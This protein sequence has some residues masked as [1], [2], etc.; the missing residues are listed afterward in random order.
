MDTELRNRKAAGDDQQDPLAST[1]ISSANKHH[2]QPSSSSTLSPD[3]AFTNGFGADPEKNGTG[4]S[5]VPSDGLTRFPLGRK[6]TETQKESLVKESAETAYGKTPNG[7]SKFFSSTLW[8]ACFIFSLL[9]L[10]VYYADLMG[11]WAAMVCLKRCRFY[12][13]CSHGS[14]KEKKKKKRKG[15]V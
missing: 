12:Y 7:T 10:I 15:M 2:H 6:L 5:R 1:G 11:C 4:H 8:F 3:S 13:W 9:F 14:H